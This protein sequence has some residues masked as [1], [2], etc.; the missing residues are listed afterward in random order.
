VSDAVRV[1]AVTPPAAVLDAFGVDGPARAL[2]GGRGA[3]SVVGDI[4]LK[5][6]DDAAE[7]AWTCELLTRIRAEGFRVAEPVT[8]VDGRWV[9]DGWTASV[10]IRGLRPL[11]PRWGDVIEAGLR[12]CD[13]AEAAREHDSGVLH[14]RTHRWAIA[15]RVAWG[16]ESIGLS[17]ETADLFGDIAAGFENV[18][19]H[20][21]FVHGDLSGNVFVDDQGTPVVLDVSP[22]LRPRPWAAAIVVCDALLW[23]LADPG[24]ARTLTAN[25]ERS[26]LFR[27][28]AFRL[29]ADELASRVGDEPPPYPIYR[30]V[31][32]SLP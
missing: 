28:L 6:A 4:V 8:T 5:P 18:S 21:H 23:H 9:H 26:L 29:V 25:G 19:D 31:I 16:E 32:A 14:A 13:A 1:R 7:A 12:F 11:S 20:P 30:T 24:L 2:V 15:D 17:S 22:Y 3:A 27:A 10:F